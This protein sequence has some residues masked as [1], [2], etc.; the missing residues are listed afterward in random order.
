MPGRRKQQCIFEL[1]LTYANVELGIERKHSKLGNVKKQGTKLWKCAKICPL[2]LHS[3]CLKH[4]FY[5]TQCLAVKQTE[6]QKARDQHWG[7]AT[8]QKN[9][10]ALPPWLVQAQKG[11]GRVG[12]ATAWACTLVAALLY[13]RGPL[14]RSLTSTHDLLAGWWMNY[15]QTINLYRVKIYQWHR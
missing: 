8:H 2:L 6:V 15:I 12:K 1:D 7:F 11:N 13:Q 5:I 14:S 3:K 4:L 10:R 9:V